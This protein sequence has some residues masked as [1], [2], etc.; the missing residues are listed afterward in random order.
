MFELYTLL[1]LKL[2]FGKSTQS[3][4]P[5]TFLGMTGSSILFDVSI[6][7]EDASRLYWHQCQLGI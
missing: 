1:T 2:K 5:S 3:A 4:V 7:K 6:K